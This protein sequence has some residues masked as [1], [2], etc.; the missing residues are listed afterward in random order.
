MKYIG[1]HVSAAGGVRN[2]PINAQKIKAT[3]FALFTK[4]QRRW[5]SKPLKDKEIK[6]FKDNLNKVGISRDFILPHASYLIN[7]DNPYKQK[8]KKSRDAFINEIQRCEK[9]NLKY[10]NFHP[11]SHLGKLSENDGLKLISE[12]VN[13]ALD[14]TD[15]LIAVIENTAG[16]GNYLGYSF[17]NIATIINGIDCKKR[18]GVC[19]DTC[20]GFAAGYD[21]RTE[22]KFKATFKQFERI[23]G[24]DK[25]CGVHLNDAKIDFNSNKDRHASL[26]KGKIGMDA[27]KIMMNDER[28]DDI[29]LILETPNPNIWKEEIALLKKYSTEKI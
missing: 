14:K 12:S 4:N 18:V 13:V 27:F 9:L 6:E 7:L 20:H 29:P 19:F 25:L 3:A 5:Q 8:L 11:G 16:Q 26:G 22:K 28:F 24:F 2:A 10:L 17:E 15:S 23:I 1:A 21:I